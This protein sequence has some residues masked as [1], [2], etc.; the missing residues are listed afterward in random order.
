MVSTGLVHQVALKQTPCW[1]GSDGPSCF[2]TKGDFMA[3]YLYKVQPHDTVLSV[4]LLFDLTY[5]EFAKL[6]PDFSTLGHRYAG[7]LKPGER[8][9]MGNSN[10]IFDRLRVNYKRRQR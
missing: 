7:D 8:L 1:A 10:N 3:E 5:E 4:C 6:N 9:V 2:W